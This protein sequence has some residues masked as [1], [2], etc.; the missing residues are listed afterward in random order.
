MPSIRSLVIVLG[1][2]AAASLAGPLDTIRVGLYDQPAADTAAVHL[3]YHA[4]VQGNPASTLALSVGT[5]SALTLTAS[6]ALEGESAYSAKARIVQDLD[7]LGAGVDL[8]YA[9]DITF[10]IRGNQAFN[11]AVALGS[12]LYR[13]DSAGVREVF[14][15]SVTTSWSTITIPMQ[16]CAFNYT[17]WM[18][19]PILYPGGVDVACI[20]DPTDALFADSTRNVA[21]RARSLRF[22]IDPTWGPGGKSIVRPT[23]VATLSLDDI[24]IARI[25]DGFPGTEVRSKAMRAARFAATYADGRLS[26]RGLEGYATVDLLSLSGARVAS[27]EV[28][29]VSGVRLDRGAYLLVARGAGRKQLSR[30]LVVAR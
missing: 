15:V 20:T 12:D 6:L 30:T 8:R 29:S 11:V 2:A 19:D 1:T 27:F 7:S 13:Y 5:D 18:L 9:S 10:R 16:P 4:T 22:Q 3:G 23:G 14:P 21:M 17:D 26:F 28:G 24:K 25:G